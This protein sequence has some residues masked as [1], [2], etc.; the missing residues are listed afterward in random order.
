MN[1]ASC[2]QVNPDDSRFCNACGAA[3]E[4][5]C[6]SCSRA[7]PPDARFCNGC[8]AA[9]GATAAP[10]GQAPRDYTPRHLA[11]KSYGHQGLHNERVLRDTFD[12]DPA[13]RD[14]CQH[15]VR[16]VF[17]DDIDLH[18]ARTRQTHLSGRDEGLQLWRQSAA[19]GKL[20]TQNPER[21]IRVS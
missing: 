4:A 21:G 6:S 10:Q 11:E 12:V 2:D 16:P 9:L 14:I 1:C 8:G 7:N 3:L 15:S 13:R 17:D 5:T 20:A 18:L 19:R